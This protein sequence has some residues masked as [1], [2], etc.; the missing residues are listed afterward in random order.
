[1]GF[2][3]V[4]AASVVCAAVLAPS[5]GPLAW[6][7]PLIVVL[8]RVLGWRSAPDSKS[9][10]HEPALDEHEIPTIEIPIED[11]IDL[12]NFHPSEIPEVVT[13][14]LEEARRKGFREV[15]V[16]HGKGTGFQRQR[17]R[18]ALS[19]HPDVESFSN[20]PPERGGWGATVVVLKA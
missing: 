18:E 15:R 11:A 5:S 20:A 10:A 2:L 7:L 8:W 3:L 6:I 19:Q 17:V 16:I 1:M 13:G 12:H 14:Y 9:E 4:F